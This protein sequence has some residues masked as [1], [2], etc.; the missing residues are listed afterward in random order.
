MT[1]VFRV[2]L[3]RIELVNA[4]LDWN[5]F[6]RAFE[7]RLREALSQYAD[8]VEVAG[9]IVTTD[10]TVNM[11]LTIWGSASNT[12]RGV[13]KKLTQDKQDIT[14]IVDKVY[15]YTLLGEIIGRVEKENHT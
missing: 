4:D 2:R 10:D 6:L 12:S 13:Y 3:E 15:D 5:K 8:S 9:R 7:E 1:E 14:E 11:S